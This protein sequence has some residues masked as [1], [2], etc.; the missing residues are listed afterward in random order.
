MATPTEEQVLY[1]FSGSPDGSGPDSRGTL[2]ADAAGNLYGETGTGGA[3]G[4]GTVFKVTPTGQESVIYSFTGGSDGAHPGGG[5]I[6]DQQGNLYGTAT[7]GG[8]VACNEGGSLPGC[9]TV[10][11]IDTSGNESVVHAFTGGSDGLDPEGGLVVDSNGNLYGT[12]AEGGTGSCFPFPNNGCG[13]VFKITPSGNTTVLYNFNLADGAVP[14]GSLVIDSEGN[15][16]GNTRFGGNGVAGPGV[17]FKVDAN[18]NETVLHRFNDGSDGDLPETNLV[19]DS[20]GNL[21]GVTEAGGTG[22]SDGCGTVFEVNASGSESI[23]YRFTGGADGGAP[24][25]SLFIDAAGDLIGTTGNGGTGSCA[26]VQPGLT[27]GGCGVIFELNPSDIET[28]LYSFDGNGDGD[29]PGGGL[30]AGPNGALYGKTISGGA[31]GDGTV[32]CLSDTPCISV[33]EP[34]SASLLAI[35]LL[36]AV[37]RRR[38]TAI[39]ARTNSTP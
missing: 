21:Y 17:V 11:K 27:P 5:L 15:L 29:N 22:C 25:G 24:F 6:I 8:D 23:L 36:G 14:Q 18:G 19:M 37:R 33:P 4:F 20:S 1:S 30:I 16:Y 7:A 38:S 31:N 13:T 28:V 10:F 3:F 35:G 32:Y 9:G 26:P 39:I 34:S 12:T 2:V